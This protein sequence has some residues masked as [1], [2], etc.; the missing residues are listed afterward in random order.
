MLGQALDDRPLWFGGKTATVTIPEI[1]ANGLT[2]CVIFFCRTAVE[3]HDLHSTDFEEI[4]VCV[5]FPSGEPVASLV[6]TVSSPLRKLHLHIAK[7]AGLQLD[8]VKLCLGDDV[9]PN[10]AASLT[11]AG[12]RDDVQLTPI[13]LDAPFDFDFDPRAS[14]G[15]EF[16]GPR[17]AKGSLGCMCAV[18][19][20]FG[21]EGGGFTE[22]HH[23]WRCSINE[24][25]GDDF[26]VGVRAMY[27]GA[28]PVTGNPR[29]SLIGCSGSGESIIQ[30]CVLT[31]D[32]RFQSRGEVGEGYELELD[33]SA[34]TLT[35]RPLAEENQMTMNFGD[36]PSGGLLPCVIFGCETAIQI[37]PPFV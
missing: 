5:R 22:G 35:V 30:G 27:L 26:C 11:E 29:G 28:P 9:L 10:S 31:N 16:L 19:K 13:V 4:S 21:G 33:C 2:P 24:Y 37:G 23:R 17:I 36:I 14:D 15:A 18:V 34:G 25:H 6:L 32:P 20:G 12:L 1:P 8:Q 7:A 3:I